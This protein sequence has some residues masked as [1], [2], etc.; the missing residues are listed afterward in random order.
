MFICGMLKFLRDAD[1]IPHV[2]GIP[3]LE[4]ICLKILPP[5]QKHMQFY[6][7]SESKLAKIYDI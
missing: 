3:E 2:I 6:N 4:E 5:S 7:D 1:V